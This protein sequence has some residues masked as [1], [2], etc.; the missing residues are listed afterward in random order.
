MPIIGH[1]FVP[2]DG[3]HGPRIQ[4]S[5][6]T[7]GPICRTVIVF[8]HELGFVVRMRDNQGPRVWLVKGT[9]G[10]RQAMGRPWAG[11]ACFRSDCPQLKVRQCVTASC[12]RFKYPTTTRLSLSLTTFHSHSSLCILILGLL[13]LSEHSDNSSRP[14]CTVIHVLILENNTLS[15]APT[16]LSHSQWYRISGPASRAVG[17]SGH[18][19]ANTL[20]QAD[21]VYTSN[22]TNVSPTTATLSA[23]VC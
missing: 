6:R 15:P 16:S 2:A 23:F 7:N 9:G 19:T 8:A 13:N 5:Q 22:T 11:E 14:P 10:Q 17:Q 18:T 1:C 20:S 12:C 4:C 3:L 21:N